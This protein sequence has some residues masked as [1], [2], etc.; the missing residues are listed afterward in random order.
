MRR[1]IVNLPDGRVEAEVQGEEP[2]IRQLLSLLRKGPPMGYVIDIVKYDIPL[3]EK[4]R[5]F[6]IRY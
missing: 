3:E 4:D 2:D 5:R 6:K 1:W